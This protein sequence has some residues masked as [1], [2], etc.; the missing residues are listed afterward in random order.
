[1]IGAL[2]RQRIRNLLELVGGARIL[3]LR[4]VIEIE[5]A[6]LVDDHVLEDGAEALRRLV[7]LGLGLRREADHLRV[8]AAFDVE[9][10]VVRPAMLIVP[11]QVAA[12]IRRERCLARA[13]EPEEDGDIAVV[14]HVRGAVH[15]Q[16][17][18]EGQ[19]V[20]HQRED[21]L[22]D[23][24]GIERAADHD[25]CPAQVDDDER[26]AAGAVLLRLCFDD[27]SV[28]NQRVGLELVQL[29]AGG[30]DE[31]RL[32]EQRVPGAVSDQPN[33]EPVCRIGAGE[34][35]DD[36]EVLMLE[37]RGDLVAEPI[38]LH[39]LQLLVDRAPPD[40]IL[41][42]RLAD[43]EFVFRRTSRVAACVDDERAALCEPALVSPQRVRVEN[44]GRGVDV[45]AAAGV[46]SVLAE[47]DSALGSDRQ[48]HAASP[49]RWRKKRDPAVAGRGPYRTHAAVLRRLVPW[50][51][52]SCDRHD[53][54][55]PTGSFRCGR[56]RSMTCRLS[57]RRAMTRRSPA[58]STSC[59]ARTAKAT[60][61]S[62][63][64]RR[65][66]L[67]TTRSARCSRSSIARPAAS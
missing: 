13:G 16:D 46:D 2:G 44:R 20:V 6:A 58:G 30:L 40:S 45:H 9:D 61:A 21:R 60:P 29:L 65:R 47:I 67:G 63:W 28:E 25:L 12:G 18:L 33:A 54:R 56:G 66:W 62:T 27:R 22:L 35:V 10:A 50:R 55:F 39:F 36:V 17:A 23:L 49:F 43:K 5:H 48:C 57:P 38:E 41:R 8:A 31:E 15:G 24:A 34:R 7:D 52:W 32:G 11:D 59:R 14:A 4:I 37:K 26:R 53:L 64:S 42:A 3:G 19:A 1:M 51:P